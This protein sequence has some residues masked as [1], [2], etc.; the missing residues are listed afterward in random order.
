M[1]SVL[2]GSSSRASSVVVLVP[3]TCNAL[4]A[5][6]AAGIPGTKSYRSSFIVDGFARDSQPRRGGCW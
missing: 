4:S 5:A 6:T 1:C 3:G 2:V